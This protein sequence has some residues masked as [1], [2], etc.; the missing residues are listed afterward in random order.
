MILCQLDFYITV[1]MMCDSNLEILNR[2][3]LFRRTMGT[4]PHLLYNIC[5]DHADV[6]NAQVS[7]KSA[8]C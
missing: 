1:F 7:M 3:L 5:S 8:H 6:R 2:Q 4:I